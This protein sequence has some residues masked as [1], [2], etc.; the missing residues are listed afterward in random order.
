VFFIIRAIKLALA[1]L[2]PGVFAVANC[3]RPTDAVRPRS[4]APSD[5]G[6]SSNDDGRSVGSVVRSV[7]PAKNDLGGRYVAAPGTDRLSEP[8]VTHRVTPD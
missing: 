8:A 2:H 1:V 6:L 3:H 5:R 7:G 4:T